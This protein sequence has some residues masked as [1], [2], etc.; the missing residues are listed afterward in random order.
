MDELKRNDVIDDF[1]EIEYRKEVGF[2]SLSF[3]LKKGVEV[4]RGV[5]REVEI[6]ITSWFRFTDIKGSSIHKANKIFKDRNVI[7]LTIEGCRHG[8]LASARKE[9]NLLDVVY[10]PSELMYYIIAGTR[11]RDN[12]VRTTLEE[13]FNQEY[14]DLLINDLRQLVRRLG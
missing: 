1:Y 9:F 11:I 4:R 10:L 14:K 13:R 6:P 2:T 5:R 8:I 3:I 12:R 7:I